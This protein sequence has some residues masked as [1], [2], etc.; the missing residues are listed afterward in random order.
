M[1]TPPVPP[2]LPAAR[3]PGKVQ[4]RN[5]T[6]FITV[7]AWVSIVLG[8]LGVLYALGQTVVAALLP[9]DLLTEMKSD[10]AFEILQLPSFI[11]WF[12][13][14]LL[15]VSVVSLVLSAAFLWVAWCLLKRREWARLGFIA[16]MAL[17]TLSNLLGLVL[18]WDMIEWMNHLQ[19]FAADPENPFDAHVQRMNM[20]SFATGFISA[21]FF[22][23]L[24]VW[25]IYKLMTPG[26]RKE[27][28]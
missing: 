4:V 11:V 16:F 18:L 19:S 13:D 2:P 10:P 22:A 8:A 25:I 5:N 14:N 23:G 12:M 3:V 27:F 21:F 1:T 6:S 9:G 7:M 17:G 24:H 15:L 28:G 20:V 26:I